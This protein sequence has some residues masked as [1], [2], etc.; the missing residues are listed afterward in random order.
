MIDTVTKRTKSGEPFISAVLHARAGVRGIPL[1]GNFELT[2]RCNFGCKMCYVHQNCTPENELSAKEWIALAREAKDKGMVFLLLTGGE[3]LIRK[4]FPE[5]YLA[6]RNMG[7]MVSINTNGSLIT[8]EILEMFRKNPPTR[9][10]VSLYGGC[11]ETY[12]SLCGIPAFDVVSRNILRLKEAGIAVKINCSITPYNGQD[13]VKVYDF[14]KKA[15]IVVNATSYMYPPVRING[16][17]YGE[18][19]ARFSAE[20]AARYMLLCREQY[21]TPEQLADVTARMPEEET[22]CTGET[23]L[24]MGCRAGRTAFWVTWDGRMLP[25]GMF[26]TDGY[27]IPRD[28]FDY[29]WEQVRQDTLKVVMPAECTGCNKR[30]RCGAC[31]AACLA[32]SG[33]TR[34]KPEYICKITH[35]HEKLTRQKYGKGE[36]PNAD[37]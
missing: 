15:G 11:N 30:E 14:A 2:A 24:P 29:A 26:P 28:G 22:E 25:C 16:K 20:E 21:L 31:A 7:I 19:P 5:I 9:I 33:D 3:P 32:E 23:G 18:A 4:D 34:I 6:I 27:S 36:S 12:Q 35:L 10:N 1:A 8:D 37:Q 13:V 17:K